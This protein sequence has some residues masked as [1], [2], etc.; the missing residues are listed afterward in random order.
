MVS[1]D[2]TGEDR[3]QR[4]R[5]QRCKGVETLQEKELSKISLLAKNGWNHLRDH[6]DVVSKKGV[7]CIE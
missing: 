4:Q 7:S 6:A 1:E 2:T 5:Q 3:Q